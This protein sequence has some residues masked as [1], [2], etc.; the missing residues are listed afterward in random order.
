M[1]NCTFLSWVSEQRKQFIHLSRRMFQGPCASAVDTEVDTSSSSLP[2][3]VSSSKEKEELSLQWK[4]S[5]PVRLLSGKRLE[6][7]GKGPILI[8]KVDKR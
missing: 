7:T 4:D 3:G 5:I 8:Q 2:A 6:E 1:E